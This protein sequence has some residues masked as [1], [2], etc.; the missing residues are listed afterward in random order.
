MSDR[1]QGFVQPPIGKLLVKNLGL[2]NPT[3]LERYDEGDPLVDGTVVVGGSGRLAESLPGL[4]D[5][6]GIAT[7]HQRR[8]GR[9][10]QGPGLRRHRPHRHRPARRAARLLHPAA[11]QP[12]DLPARRRPRHAAGVASSGSERV[13]QRALEGFT[14]TLG[15]EI[16][17][18]GTV[19]LVYVADGAEAAV[20]ST[21]GFLLSPKSAYVSGQVIRIGTTGE[22][23]R[24]GQR[25]AAAARP[26]RSPS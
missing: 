3:P 12:R 10:V 18:G 4:L 20:A 11:P 13:A 19:Q 15:K 7:H 24:R 26:A 2:P 23:R 8:R 9:E 6:L 14:R 22:R 5:L 1:Y 16:G 21:L 25:L 17:R